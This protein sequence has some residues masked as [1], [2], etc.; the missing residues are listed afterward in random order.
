M[1]RP[2][3]APDSFTKAAPRNYYIRKFNNTVKPN[4]EEKQ[5]LLRFAA[6]PFDDRINYQHTYKDLS[7]ALIMA[8]LQDAGSKLFEDVNN[9]PF[10][11]ICRQM[12]LVQGPDEFIRPKNFA[13]MFFS[14]HPEKIFPMA[15]IE[16]VNFQTPTADSDF[17]EIYFKGPLQYQLKEVL[18]YF[19]TYVVKELVRKVSYQA[20]ALRN[21][22]FPYDHTCP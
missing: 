21:F 1:D 19:K 7:P 22:N 20:Q 8:F 11:T 3:E 16:M 4:K 15:Q 12:N 9:A 14:A 13:L 2:Y 18:G 17:S 5:E 10:L 6:I